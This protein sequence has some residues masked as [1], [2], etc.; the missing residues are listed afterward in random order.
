MA[1]TLFSKPFKG[2]VERK[3]EPIRCLAFH[4]DVTHFRGGVVLP[5]KCAFFQIIITKRLLF[6]TITNYISLESS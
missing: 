6:K 2:A 4:D 5:E 1:T 3:G